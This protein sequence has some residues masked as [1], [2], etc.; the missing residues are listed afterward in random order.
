[1]CWP[2]RACSAR[3]LGGPG[4]RAPPAMRRSLGEPQEGAWSPAELT[5]RAE[6]QSRQA[7]ATKAQSWCLGGQG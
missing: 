7:R 1:M 2:L 4:P 3:E 5:A 6:A